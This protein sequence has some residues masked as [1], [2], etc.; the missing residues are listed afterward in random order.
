[1]GKMKE[2][3]QIPIAQHPHVRLEDLLNKDECREFLNIFNYDKEN[4]LLNE[5]LCWE[6]GEYSSIKVCNKINQILLVMDF[7]PKD[8]V[9]L[10]V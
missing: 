3:A 2:I 10:D 5:T 8:T 1:M 7:N 4:T 6:I 9:Y